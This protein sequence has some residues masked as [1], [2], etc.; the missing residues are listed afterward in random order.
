[1]SVPERGYGN[2]AVV[3]AMVDALN[4]A[5]I[6]RLVSYYTDDVEVDIIRFGRRLKGAAAVGR[7]IEDAFDALDGFCN[8]VVGIYGDGEIIVLEVVARGVAT[9]PFAGRE[10]GEPLDAPEVYVYTFRDGRI[11]DV[12]AY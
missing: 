3:A 5:D 1:M 6:D 11:A 2:R 10:V 4:R 8:E 9:R 12:R 7:W